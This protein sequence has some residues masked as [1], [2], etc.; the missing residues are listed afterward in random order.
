[1]RIAKAR[2]V[3]PP[4]LRDGQL[5][6]GGA[7]AISGIS[8]LKRSYRLGDSDRPFADMK[9]FVRITHAPDH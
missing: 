8:P 2:F 7:R 6:L 4:G 3:S 9:N 5:S 1:M